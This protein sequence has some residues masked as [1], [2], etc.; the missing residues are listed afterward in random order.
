MLKQ[1]LASASGIKEFGR[2]VCREEFYKRINHN[3]AIYE[4]II[5]KALVGQNRA[6]I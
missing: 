1:A 5:S 2:G 3:S 6:V 4:G